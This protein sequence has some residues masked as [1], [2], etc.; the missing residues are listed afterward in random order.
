M[1]LARDED[2]LII[3]VVAD[4]DAAET[5]VI[6]VLGFVDIDQHTTTMF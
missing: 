3:I 4:T 2:T 5:P 1:R 6:L